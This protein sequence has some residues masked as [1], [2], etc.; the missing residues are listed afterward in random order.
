MTSIRSRGRPCQERTSKGFS[1]LPESIHDKTPVNPPT[2]LFVA[3]YIEEDLQKILRTVLEARAPPSDGPR[4]KP[5]KA[6]S[7]DVYRGKS[8]MECYNFCQQC[9]DHFATAGAKGPNR[10]LFAAFF[11]RDRINFRWQQYKWKYEAESTVPITWEEFKTF[12]CQSL[13]DSRAFVDSYWAKIKRDSPYQQEDVLDWAA[14]LE[15]LQA[16][17]REF[18]SLAAPNKDTMIRYF[19]ESLWPSI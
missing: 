5:L 6:R 17:F 9:E 12:L 15:H 4:E 10:I 14:H 3:K 7:P 11:L 18:D 1:P 16:V 13:G 19:R 8:H 2:K